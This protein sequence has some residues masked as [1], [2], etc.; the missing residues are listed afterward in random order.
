MQLYR[1]TKSDLEFMEQDSIATTDWPTST[2]KLLRSYE[3]EFLARKITAIYHN[4]RG[5]DLKIPSAQLQRLPRDVYQVGLYLLWTSLVSENIPP[6]YVLDPAGPSVRELWLPVS[7][8]YSIKDH[9][10]ITSLNVIDSRLP[11]KVF[12][13]RTVPRTADIWQS[14][15]EGPEK[16]GYG[17][18]YKDTP[19]LELV[20]DGPKDSTFVLYERNLYITTISYSKLTKTMYIGIAL[21]AQRME[22]IS[23][24]LHFTRADPVYCCVVE[25][26]IF[27][28]EIKTNTS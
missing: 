13:A 27:R 16:E 28:P 6:S 19:E 12:K 4:H 20:R 2:P 11:R 8:D 14:E 23:Q 18:E 15:R 24:Y 10:V 1:P 7:M 25:G 22:F 9:I 26:P 3:R 5:L 21:S 17:P